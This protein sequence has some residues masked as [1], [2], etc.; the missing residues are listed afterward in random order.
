[1]IM[2]RLIEENIRCGVVS[3]MPN[4]WGKKEK[5]IEMYL[6]PYF[7][8]GNVIFSSSIEKQPIV[9]NTFS[10]FGRGG[11]DDPPDALAIIAEMS[12]A[13]GASQNGNKRYIGA[14]RLNSGRFNSMFGGIY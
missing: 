3:Y 6:C 12:R 14:G 10:F 4:K 13:P 1:M 2:K 11:R 8:S 7:S 9:L 5:R